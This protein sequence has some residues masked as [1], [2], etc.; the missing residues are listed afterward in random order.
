MLRVERALLIAGPEDK[1]LR[2]ERED[3]VQLGGVNLEGG[4]IV[5]IE[6]EVIDTRHRA[7]LAQALERVDERRISQDMLAG[8][9]RRGEIRREERR[10][11]TRDDELVGLVR[12]Q[13]LV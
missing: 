12:R 8:F 5:G 11:V 7:A 1:R 2:S 9:T 4:S 6:A 13:L 10:N 3:L